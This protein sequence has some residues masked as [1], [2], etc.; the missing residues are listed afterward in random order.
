MANAAVD[1]C[2]LHNAKHA[3]VERL[4]VSIPGTVFS[5]L[6]IAG[7][8]DRLHD[9]RS[10]N[11]RW[12]YHCAGNSS[13]TPCSLL[14][15]GS[16]L[17]QHQENVPAYY[18]WLVATISTTRGFSPLLAG[19]GRSDNGDSTLFSQLPSRP[20]A[21]YHELDSNRKCNVIFFGLVVC[22]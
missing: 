19:F 11:A 5:C 6:S 15:L 9:S 21:Y 22:K 2:L 17:L 13:K 3:Y 4:L 7:T 12:R 10:P 8:A 18:L 1:Q 16:K 14:L 20:T